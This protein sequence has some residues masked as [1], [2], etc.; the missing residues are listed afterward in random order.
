MTLFPENR[1]EDMS[2]PSYY[3]WEK[4]LAP[5]VVIQYLGQPIDDK[6][7]DDD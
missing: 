5:L 4:F 2:Q 3:K 7:N 1:F 6:G